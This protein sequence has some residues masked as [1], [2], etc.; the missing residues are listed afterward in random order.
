M[1]RTL[2]YFPF[3]CWQITFDEARRLL[4]K[5]FSR[6]IFSSKIWVAKFRVW[7]IECGLSVRLYTNQR[8]QVWSV[9]IQNY[10]PCTV[11]TNQPWSRGFQITQVWPITHTW[12]YCVRPNI[13]TRHWIGWF[14]NR[15]GT[16]D[17]DRRAHAVVWFCQSVTK[18]GYLYMPLSSDIPIL[19]Q[20]QFNAVVVHQNP[21]MLTNIAWNPSFDRWKQRGTMMTNSQWADTWS[22]YI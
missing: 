19:L 5:F 18:F 13:I 20:N 16:S 7:L 15:M 10:Y 1:G 11:W 21:Y 14:S 3:Q 12:P 4:F 6:K 17:D 8:S 22:A 2:K 9:S